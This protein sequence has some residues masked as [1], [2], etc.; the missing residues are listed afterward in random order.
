M[1]ERHYKSARASR[2]AEVC[3]AL[4]K[5]PRV[6]SNLKDPSLYREQLAPQL[7]QLSA[8]KKSFTVNRSGPRSLEEQPTT[9][10]M[11][12][13]R[14]MSDAICISNRHVICSLLNSKQYIHVYTH[15]SMCVHICC[16]HTYLY[17]IYRFYR[18]IIQFSICNLYV[19]SMSLY[20]WINTYNL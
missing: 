11:S 8:R 2:R 19:I 14:D 17:I 18:Y 13:N 10:A 6:C 9:Y 7:H 5:S 1:A 4:N 12:F 15:D 20:I 16:V 3:R